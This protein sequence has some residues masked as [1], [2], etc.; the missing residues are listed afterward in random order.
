MLDL[1]YLLENT[2]VISN[3]HRKKEEGRK[4]YWGHLNQGKTWSRG[5]RGSRYGDL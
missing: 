1:E 3:K 4:T 2:K 5:V